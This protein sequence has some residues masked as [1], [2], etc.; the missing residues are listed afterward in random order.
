MKI[1][2]FYDIMRLYNLRSELRFF[3]FELPYYDVKYEDVKFDG[4]FKV[5]ESSE[6]YLDL[7]DIVVTEKQI[8]KKNSSNYYSNF[9]DFLQSVDDFHILENDFYNFFD[10]LV[11]QNSKL[12]RPKIEGSKVL[13]ELKQCISS[14][15]PF[16]LSNFKKRTYN[17]LKSFDKNIKQEFND[18]SFVS[19][20]ICDV[21]FGLDPKNTN[22]VSIK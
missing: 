18:H 13:G 21:L 16:E 2:T 5:T 8:T 22:R 15:L 3:D 4:D 10:A 20:S 7:C 17:L 1:I 9:I 6:H 14:K 12:E 19:V 11:N